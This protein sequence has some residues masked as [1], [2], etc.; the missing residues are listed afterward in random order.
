MKRVLFFGIGLVTGAAAGAGLAYIFTKNACEKRTQEAIDEMKH[1]YE[2]SVSKEIKGFRKEDND[3]KEKASEVVRLDKPP[4]SEMSSL[5]N[6]YSDNNSGHTD[7]N[8][9][10]YSGNK[11]KEVDDKIESI[12]NHIK[13]VTE[14]SIEPAERFAVIERAEYVKKMNSGYA[15]RDYS[16]DPGD[17]QWIDEMSGSEVEVEELPFDPI[18]IQWNDLDQC[19]ILDE[20]LKSVYMV[21]RI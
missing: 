6:S 20:E 3:E 10:N 19:Y 1:F 5:V 13:E 9:Q 12:K 15:D 18:I 7:Y 14:R 11:E 2:G 17:D 21:E 16:F 4:I 8:R